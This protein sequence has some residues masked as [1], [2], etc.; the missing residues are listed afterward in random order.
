MA[1]SHVLLYRA[2]DRVEANLLAHALDNAGIRVD[3]AGGAPTCGSAART[4]GA[5]AR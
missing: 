5:G 4:A 2:S 1:D 3:L